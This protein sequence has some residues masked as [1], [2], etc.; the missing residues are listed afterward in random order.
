L[1]RVDAK[2][3]LP[4]LAEFADSFHIEPQAGRELNRTDRQQTGIAVNQGKQSVLRRGGGI[5]IGLAQFDALRGK[6][7]PRQP[8][9]A[10]VQTEVLPYCP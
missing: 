10:F 4:L 3:D 6:R 8:V 1:N 9:R 7:L 2:Q 5:Q